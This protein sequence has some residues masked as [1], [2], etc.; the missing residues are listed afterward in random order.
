MVQPSMFD[1]IKTVSFFAGQKHIGNVEYELKDT[2]CYDVINGVSYSHQNNIQQKYPQDHILQELH[3]EAYVGIPIVDSK[4]ETIGLVF[5][6]NKKPLVNVDKIISLLKIFSVRIAAELERQENESRLLHAQKMEAIG[7]LTGGVAHDFNN[8]LASILGYTELIKESEIIKHDEKLQE[9]L[10]QIYSSGIRARDLVQQMLAYS[11]SSKVIADEIM[12]S[13][14]I[15]QVVEMLR[16][17]TSQK[18]EIKTEIDDENLKIL[19]DS[20]QLQQTLVNLIINARHAIIN[21]GKITI[22][23]NK[24]NNAKEKCESCK[25]EFTGN[26]VKIS[27][28]DSGKG[29]EPAVLQRI[30][31]PFYTTSRL[32]ESTGMGLSMVH[33]IVHS[34]N[35]HI[36]ITSSSDNGTTINLFYPASSIEVTEGVNNIDDAA[37][38][39]I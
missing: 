10:G 20:A 7:Q 2:P 24:I 22:T 19:S 25:E 21:T 4:G 5:V 28:Q 9:F 16:E 23:L 35:G 29:I 36:T 32:G 18:I 38:P 30:F 27:I 15:N 1:R 3:A 31:D 11:R 14:V 26:L 37:L 39:N 34:N 8:I 13:R 12:P 33:G 6:L 17:T